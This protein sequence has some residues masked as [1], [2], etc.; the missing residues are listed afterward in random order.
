[1]V[2]EYHVNKPRSTSLFANLRNCCTKWILTG[3]GYPFAL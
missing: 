1:M 3:K 2:R